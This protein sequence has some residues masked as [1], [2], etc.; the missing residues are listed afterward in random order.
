MNWCVTILL[1]S[2]NLIQVLVVLCVL[3]EPIMKE[4]LKSSCAFT[5]LHSANFG[6]SH[7]HI[8][9]TWFHC[10]RFLC[11][12]IISKL[13]NCVSYTILNRETL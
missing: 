11:M 1:G 4:F 3:F 7:L 6:I 2:T 13:D 10:K 8:L 12:Y 9:E 5:E